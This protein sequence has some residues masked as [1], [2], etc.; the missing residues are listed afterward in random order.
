VKLNELF[1]SDGLS[2]SDKKKIL[3]D[4]EKWSGGF[5]PSDCTPEECEK[6]AR[7]GVSSEFKTA[8][9]LKFLKS[10]CK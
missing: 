2:A 5:S 1:E 6:Y 8:D 7:H 3:A 10:C 4:F 9:V